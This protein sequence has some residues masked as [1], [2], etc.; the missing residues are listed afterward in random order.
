MIPITLDSKWLSPFCD[1][2][3]YFMGSRFTRPAALINPN[4]NS[5]LVM[6]HSEIY[7]TLLCIYDWILSL[8]N[9]LILYELYR[10]ENPAYIHISWRIGFVNYY[11]EYFPTQ[12]KKSINFTCPRNL[13]H[14]TQIRILTV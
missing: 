1:C 14:L 4:I 3:C 8:F 7:T 2:Y 11:N 13:N 5:S 12:T 10:A 6:V 9:L